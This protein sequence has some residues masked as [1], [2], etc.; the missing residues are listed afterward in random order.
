MADKY[1]KLKQLKIALQMT[2]A[3][4]NKLHSCKDNVGIYGF[5]MNRL[6][7]H[8]GKFF[9]LCKALRVEPIIKSNYS[10]YSKYHA[11]IYYEGMELYCLYDEPTEYNK[12]SVKDLEKRFK[13]LFFDTENKETAFQ[14]LKEETLE[15]CKYKYRNKQPIYWMNTYKD[16]EKYLNRHRRKQESYESRYVKYLEYKKNFEPLDEDIRYDD[17]ER[18][19]P[20]YDWN[21]P[22]TFRQWNKANY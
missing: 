6:G 3:A 1:L 14:K 17:A 20:N 5:D 11:H 7:M 18:I 13:E 8:K 19:R 16:F 4:Q 21:V 12:Y 2:K 9:A 22:M 15:K 10:E